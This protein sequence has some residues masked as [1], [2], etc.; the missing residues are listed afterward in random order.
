L[1]LEKKNLNFGYEVPK[2]WALF[3][4]K[5]AMDLCKIIFPQAKKRFIGDRSEVCFYRSF[6]LLKNHPNF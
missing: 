5:K 4:A 6:S 1:R 2:I 3:L